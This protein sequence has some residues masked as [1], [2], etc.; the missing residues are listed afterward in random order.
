M[1]SGYFSHRRV[2]PSMSVNRNVTWPL[3]GTGKRYLLRVPASRPLTVSTSS[4]PGASPAL[5]RSGA[6]GGGQTVR[7]TAPP[8]YHDIEGTGGAVKREGA[9]RARRLALPAPG[10]AGWSALPAAPRR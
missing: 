6:L 8:P 7:R 3:G 10:A 9:G 4:A 1:A 5:P 2:E